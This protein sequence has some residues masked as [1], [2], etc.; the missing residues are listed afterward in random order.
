MDTQRIVRGAVAVLAAVGLFASP[1]LAVDLPGPSVQVTATVTSGLTFS[2]TINE[3]LPNPATPDPSDTIIG[4]VV[5]AMNFNTLAS[6]GT[7]DPD[8]GGPLPP[9]PRAL[10]SLKA[11]QAFFGVN[12]QQRAF[13]I[14]QTAGPL[15][16]GPNAIPNNAFPVT[17]LSGVGGNP[18]TPLPPNITVG[19]KT[20]AV[21]TNI[22][23]FS[24]S[25]GPADTM[26]ATYGITDNSGL[27]TPNT[28][29]LDQPAG[30]YTTTITYTATVI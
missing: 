15:Q 4:P 5:T 19:A 14:K 27:P 17:P 13:T 1:V 6:N 25:G 8:G 2:V 23:L 22:V 7:F 11:F 3:L 24:S 21:G 18:A 20:S 28:I 16:S 26:A 9:Q 29:P 12:S 10:N 30:T